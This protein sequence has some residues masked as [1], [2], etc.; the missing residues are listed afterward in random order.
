[1]KD[2]HIIEILESGPFSSLTE[3]DLRAISA[4]TESCAA[5]AR[6]YEAARISSLLV[7]ARAGETMEP[8][9]FFQT[10]VLAALREQQANNKVPAFWRLWKTAGALVASMAMTTAALAVLSFV[11]PGVTEPAATVALTPP[12]A[13][14]L[15]FDQSTSEEMTDE[16]VLNAIYVE[17]EEAR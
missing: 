2:K 12:S 9:P 15:V 16:Q 10:R 17:Q 7:K 4:H 8:S 14:E 11:A 6:A 1:M 13:E 5:C 3:N